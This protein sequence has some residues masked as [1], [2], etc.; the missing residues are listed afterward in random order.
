LARTLPDLRRLLSI[1]GHPLQGLRA[2]GEDPALPRVRAVALLHRGA[3]AEGHGRVSNPALSSVWAMPCRLLL[4]IV[5]GC[6]QP[7]APSA[8]GRS[9]ADTGS[10]AA[11]RSADIDALRDGLTKRH[12]DPFAHVSRSEFDAMAE[13]LK[14]EAAHMDNVRYVLGL[15]KLAASIGDGH[16]EVVLETGKGPCATSIPVQFIGL[17]DGVFVT[18]APTDHAQLLGARVVEV[19]SMSLA[20]ASARIRSVSACEND[21]DARGTVARFLKYDQLLHGLGITPARG[22][23]RLKVERQS[24][25]GETRFLEAAIDAVGPQVG[26]PGQF[27]PDP[28]RIALPPGRVS[29]PEPYWH[30]AL[31][32][33]QA[34]YCRYDRCANGPQATVAEWS[35]EVMREV[36][37]HEV[38]KVIIDLRNNAGGDSSLLH[39][40][41]EALR[42]WV[43]SDPAARR[44][45]ALIGPGTFSSG[46]T[47]ALNLRAF[48]AAKLVGET[49]G[50]PI[51]TFG[52]VRS[53]TLPQSGLKVTYGSK[54]HDDPRHP[55]EIIPDVIAPMRSTDYFSGGDPAMDAVKADPIP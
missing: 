5:C 35:R 53:F 30:Q 8:I 52:E 14:A 10:V 36:S 3:E 43:R 13:E 4:G 15:R 55:I 25:Q 44:V 31:P 18:A 34:V 6:G 50:Q 33:A 24:A 28:T 19:G 22:V 46:I 49:P 32:D 7:H 23:V 41:I 47:N 45:Y 17:A 16:T 48:V 26:V 29:R 12:A 51:G 11:D 38:R 20:D 40:L 54:V 21:A 37:D 42:A 1:P 2:T 39:P 27:A 9:A